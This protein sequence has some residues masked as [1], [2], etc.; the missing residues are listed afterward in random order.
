[1]KIGFEIKGSRELSN[2]LSRVLSDSDNLIENA[3][4]RAALKVSGDAKKNAPVDSGLLRSSIHAKR[5]ERHGNEIVSKVG[6]A[7]EYAPYVEFGTGMRGA[8]SNTNT[9]VSVSHRKDWPGQVAKPF[10]WPAL[11]KNKSEINKMIAQEIRKSIRR[12]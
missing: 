11:R 7:V 12:G 3:I 4:N 10:L 1:M 8:A 2:K 6:T 9:E 5:A